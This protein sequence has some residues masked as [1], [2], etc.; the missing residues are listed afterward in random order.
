MLAC[1]SSHSL[2]FAGEVVIHC[3]YEVSNLYLLQFTADSGFV[4]VV[5]TVL[6]VL[7]FVRLSRYQYAH[8]NIIVNIFIMIIS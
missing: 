2:H 7:S 8:N 5:L 1:Y 6:A 4:L 3:K